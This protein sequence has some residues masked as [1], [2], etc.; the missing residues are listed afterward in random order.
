M[1]MTFDGEFNSLSLYNPTTGQGLFKTSFS[2]GTQSNS[3]ATAYTS[4]TLVDNKEQEI[5]VDPSYQGTG[6]APLGLNP[7]SI[8]NGIL[9]ITGTTAPSADVSS[10]SGYQY[11][12]GLLTTAKS[13]SQLYGYFEIK[14]E[15]PTG[16]GAWPAFWLLPSNGAW[17]PEI[18]A[19]EQVGGDKIYQTTHT[20][21]TGSPTAI[22]FTT[23]LSNVS[24]TFHTYGVLWTAQNIDYYI[25]GVE[26]ASMATPS[27]ANTPMY[28]L[29]NL[30]LGGTFPGNVPTN[31]TSAQLKIA[32]IHAYS[33]NSSE[34][35]AVASSGNDTVYVTQSATDTLPASADIVQSGYTYSLAGTGAHTLQLTGS[36]NI[37]ATGNN[38]GDNISGNAGNNTL[39][40]GTGNDTITAGSGNDTLTGRG[41]TDTFVFNVSTGQDVITDFSGHDILDISSFLKA[42]Y[43]PT[44]TDS[45]ANT[46]L[47]FS[48][49]ASIELLGVHAA[50][51]I[52]TGVGYTH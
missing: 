24:N 26:V 6:T 50:S 34:A 3:G 31:F 20:D 37:N 28:M 11:T 1:T 12:S 17:P 13:F 16:Q 42:G 21:Q 40:G 7:F 27:D 38:L 30:A 22:G 18:D 52:S 47:T 29:V 8:S 41:G 23:D 19:L 48:N 46:T 14:A 5:Y 9:T 33:L 51:L 49:G 36:G 2:S 43:T 45:G 32:Y 15:L 35:T 39:T 44:L 10:L 25:D 4:H